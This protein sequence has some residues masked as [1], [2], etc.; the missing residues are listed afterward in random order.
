MTDDSRKYDFL[1][2]G[3]GIYGAAAARV[4][5]E[6]GF[7]VLVAERRDHVAGSAYTRDEDGICV[8]AYG[9]HIFHTSDD[10]VWEFV[11][12]FA[13]FN[14]FRDEPKAFYRGRYYSLPFNMNTFYEMWG[15]STPEEAKQIISEQI[16]AAGLEG[17]T[18]S[19][20]EEQAVSQV[21]TDI[22]EKLIKG[23]TEKQWG[24]PCSELPAEIIRRI[25]VRFEFNNDYFG[26]KYQGIPE[27]GFTELIQNMLDHENIEVITGADTRGPEGRKRYEDMADRIIWTGQIDEYYDYCFGPLEYRGLRFENEKIPGCEY[28]QDRAV[29]NY[30]DID[31]PWTRIIEHRHF[32]EDPEFLNSV[33]GSGDQADGS[34]TEGDTTSHGSPV[35]AADMKDFTIITREYPAEWKPGDDAF[36]PVRSPEDLERYERY[37]SLAQAGGRVFFG[38]RL[39]SYKYYDM[40]DAVAA[41]MA[42]AE[43]LAEQ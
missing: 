15:V 13:R 27:C 20:L 4:L 26:D 42:D 10:R 19:D 1:I 5:A 38:G 11:N 7:R 39:G 21:G 31:V 33:P 3:A 2:V 29:I 9:A 8:H 25:P 22:F 23:Y 28:Y 41:A 43:R 14:S 30:T 16:R 6:R 34:G 36:Y 17:V 40:D 37:K 12:R 24:R 32:A 35:R 18:P